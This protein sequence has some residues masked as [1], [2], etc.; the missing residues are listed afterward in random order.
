MRGPSLL[1]LRSAFDHRLDLL[2]CGRVFHGGQVPR[3][4]PRRAAKAMATWPLRL[5][6]TFEHFNEVIRIHRQKCVRLGSSGG[7]GPNKCARNHRQT[8][9]DI[10]NTAGPGILGQHQM[11]GGHEVIKVAHGEQVSVE[12]SAP[13]MS[14]SSV[15]SVQWSWQGVSWGATAGSLSATCSEP[16]KPCCSNSKKTNSLHKYKCK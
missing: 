5:S 11:I 6:A 14:G 10:A 15:W 4:A 8:R 1:R 9:R 13:R 7:S 3:G 12:V 16:V 2:Q